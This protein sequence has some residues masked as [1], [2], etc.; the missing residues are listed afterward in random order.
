MRSIA[1]SLVLALSMVAVMAAQQQTPP[2][3]T[4]TPQVT[5]QTQTPQ[6]PRRPA[7]PPGTAA[8]QVG[9][10]WAK[11]QGAAEPRYTGGKWIEITYGRPI[12]RGRTAV[13]GA[14]ADYGKKVTG[15]GAPLWRA[16]AN[17]TTRLVTEVPLVFGDKTLPAGEY[18]LFVDL[19]PNAWT[20]VVSKQPFQPK[21]DPNNKATTW[22]AYNY[23][24]A[25]DVL[26]V[27]MT[28][29]TSP[30]SVDQF[31]IGFVDMTQKSGKIAMWWE[32]ELATVAFTVGS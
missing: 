29:S 17:Q 1:S 12:L 7:S 15:E 31:T 27:P 3:P 11:A 22:G 26:R 8:T 5:Q 2:A 30:H 23:D 20:L 19:K 14:G 6:P 13:F 16:G 21:Y 32:K 4:Q 24:P 28:M 10:E 25:Q 18:S 9:G